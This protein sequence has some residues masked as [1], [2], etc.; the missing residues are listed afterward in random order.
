LV[1]QL[2][3]I[4]AESGVADVTHAHAQF[5]QRDGAPFEEPFLVKVPAEPQRSEGGVLVVGA[6]FRG[7]LVTE[8]EIDE[9]AVVPDVVG[10]D[11]ESE[12]T[13]TVFAAARAAFG[14]S[15]GHRGVFEFVR[16]DAQRR[17]RVA[18]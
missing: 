17:E 10:V 4:G 16:K 15:R 18:F 5:E 7:A 14:V 12:H 1:G 6:E 13:R 9:I 3:L 2:R 8:R 11:V